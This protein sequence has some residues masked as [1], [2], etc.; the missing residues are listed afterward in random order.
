MF[1][2]EFVGYHQVF[3]YH[4]WFVFFLNSITSNLFS[5]GFVIYVQTLCSIEHRVWFGFVSHTNG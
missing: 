5:K 2:I 1:Y 3:L 4:R